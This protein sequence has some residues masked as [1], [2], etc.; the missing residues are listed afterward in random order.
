MYKE[1]WIHSLHYFEFVEL[2][3]TSNS[4]ITMRT[5]LLYYQQNSVVVSTGQC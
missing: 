5:L 1:H 2:T 3:L 4:L